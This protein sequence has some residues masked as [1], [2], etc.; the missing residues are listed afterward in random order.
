M[1][2]LEKCGYISRGGFNTFLIVKFCLSCRKKRGIQ[3]GSITVDQ[4][5]CQN[6]YGNFFHEDHA[7]RKLEYNLYTNKIIIGYCHGNRNA[8][9]LGYLEGFLVVPHVL[10]NI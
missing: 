6:T 9:C 7:G 3:I 2:C 4:D 10:Q 5:C 1:V 8:T